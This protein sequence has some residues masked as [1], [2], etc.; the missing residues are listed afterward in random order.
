[1][2]ITNILL[3]FALF[4]ISNA[5]KVQYEFASLADISEISKTSYGKSLLETVSLTLSSG[6]GDISQV[7]KLL[8]DLLFK[9]NRDQQADDVAWA[10]ENARL[11]AKIARLTKE[12]EVLRKEILALKAERTKYEKLVDRVLA[13]LKQYHQQLAQNRKQATD[14]TATRA[15]DAADY[16]R[17]Q[18][19]HMDI[20]NALT[21][22]IKELH[23]LD[24]SV[25]GHGRPTH[26]GEIDEE[27]RDR[28]NK[29]F[30]EITKDDQE[31][32]LFIQM[33]TDADQK[34]LR[35]LIRLLEKLRMSTEKSFNDDKNAEMKSKRIYKTLM[36][37]IKSDIT[38]L[39]AMIVT[40]NTNLKNY[41]SRIARLTVEI[42]V[43]TRLRN[44]LKSERAATITER[45][46]KEKQYNDDKRERRS[47]MDVVERLQ[48]MVK[49]RLA[50]MSAYLKRETSA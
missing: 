9:L 28:L 3:I 29:S 1:M 37:I 42:G 18:N 11:L 21:E 16:R 39:G 33:A 34:S 8:D 19:E 49:T 13:N 5:T 41:R 30:L 43:K 12:I 36:S 7:Q 24:G 4:L 25:S 2:K 46:A 17:S 48:T 44:S 47:E 26:V 23:N 15:L 35:K 40:S 50:N 20:I 10:K 22:V 32:A 45:L 38:K 27:K 31:A 6:D 14:L